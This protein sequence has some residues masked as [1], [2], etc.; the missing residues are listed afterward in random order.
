[1]ND[2]C[3][4]IQSTKVGDWSCISTSMEADIYQVACEP[5]HHTMFALSQLSE[6]SWQRTKRYFPWAKFKIKQNFLLLFFSNL[7]KFS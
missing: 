7:C 4:I 5:L 1:M 6:L 2:V 3:F